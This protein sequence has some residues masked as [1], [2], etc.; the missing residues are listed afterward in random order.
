MVSFKCK[1][2]SFATER[3]YNLRRHLKNK[4]K[5]AKNTVVPINPT[6]AVRHLGDGLP[7][8]QPRAQNQKMACILKKSSRKLWILY[9][10]G[11]QR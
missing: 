8:R 11:F 5:V 6:N 9:E 2:C 7:R 1:E 3:S 10:L 4:H